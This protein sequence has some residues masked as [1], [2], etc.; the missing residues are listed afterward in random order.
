MINYILLNTTEQLS[1]RNVPSDCV[2]TKD[3]A[4][5]VFVA[6]VVDL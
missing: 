5:G 4:L 3:L 6:L 2:P 1:V